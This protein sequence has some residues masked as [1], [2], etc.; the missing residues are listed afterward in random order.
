MYGATSACE[1]VTRRTIEGPWD[2]E[3]S[4]IYCLFTFGIATVTAV[5]L[6]VYCTGFG[7]SYRGRALA[8]YKECDG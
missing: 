8:K 5:S 3:F 4:G 7:R 1:S 2:F 6:L